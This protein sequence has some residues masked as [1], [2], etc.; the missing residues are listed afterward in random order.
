MNS[1]PFHRNKA[2]QQVEKIDY[3]RALST[4]IAIKKQCRVKLR[5]TERKSI[6]IKG[7]EII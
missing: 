4:Y 3:K 5:Q 6:P 7:A 1:L 2:K